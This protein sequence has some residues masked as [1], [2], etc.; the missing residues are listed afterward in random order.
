MQLWIV[1]HGEA[2][3]CQT[4]DELRALTAQGQHDIQALASMLKQQAITPQRVLVSPYLRTQQTWAI[5]QA[6]NAWSQVAEVSDRITPDAIISDALQLLQGAQTTL[7]V[8][9]QP[10]VS[11]LLAVLIDGHGRYAIDYPMYPGS[12][13]CLR[14]DTW[15]P[16][17]AKLDALLS[18]PY[19]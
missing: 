5:L 11:Q 1:R 8:S 4:S 12:V 6:A 9:H 16:G 17:A 13:A 14:L 3:P 10:L 18:P 15:L 2:E 7:M 19:E